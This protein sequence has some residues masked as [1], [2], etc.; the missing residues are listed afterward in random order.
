MRQRIVKN[1]AAAEKTEPSAERAPAFTSGKL[2]LVDHDMKDLEYYSEILRNE[3]Y[4]V[5][6]CGRYVEAPQLLESV[7]FD[8][9]VTSQGTWPHEG[10]SVLTLALEIDRKTPVIVLA[11]PLDMCC[12]FEAMR[13][14]A[15]D[16]LEKPVPPAQLLWSVRYHLRPGAAA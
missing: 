5:M 4:E 8:L 3:G 16:Y 11:D 10:L 12:C 7:V 2:L 15:A 14:G 1:S 6:T 9:I 13:L